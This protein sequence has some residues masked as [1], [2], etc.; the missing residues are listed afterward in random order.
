MRSPTIE[1][2]HTRK[3]YLFLFR[4][5][6]YQVIHVLDGSCGLK[7]AAFLIEAQDYRILNSWQTPTSVKF[8]HKPGQT[9]HILENLTADPSPTRLT[10]CAGSTRNP[11]TGAVT[12]VGDSFPAF[13]DRLVHGRQDAQ[14][15]QVLS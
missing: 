15:Q 12:P 7:N 5:L 4:S 14:T 1:E 2:P 13:T 9:Q 10:A 8:L 3:I 6:R 11:S